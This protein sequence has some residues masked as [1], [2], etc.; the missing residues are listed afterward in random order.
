MR[1]EVPR[2]GRQVRM[3]V[4]EVMTTPAVT[5]TPDATCPGIVEVLLEHGI[6]GLPVVDGQGRLAGIVTEADLVAKEAYGFRRRRALAMVADY[7]AGRDPQWVRKAAGR[8]ARDVM[9]TGAETV[10]PDD[11]VAVAARRMVE[12]GHKRLPVVDD[13]GVLVGVVSRHD[14]LRPFHRSDAVILADVER[15]VE[16]PLYLPD[17]H[18]VRATVMGGVVLLVG[19]VRWP[20]DA[21]VVEAFVAKVD[22]VVGVDNQL[23]AREAEPR[24]RD[25]DGHPIG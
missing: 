18:T 22:G 7:L 2:T 23:R 14:L 9:T 21:A 3:K 5:V 16:D 25:L 24:L 17:D 8:T 19:T 13:D 6:S 10:T 15:L 4:S 20:S 11:E 12:S 1:V